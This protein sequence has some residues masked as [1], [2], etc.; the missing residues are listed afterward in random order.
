MAVYW[1]N[2]YSFTTSYNGFQAFFI[3]FMSIEVL[4]NFENKLHFRLKGKIFALET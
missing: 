1:K 2:N 3:Y 4:T